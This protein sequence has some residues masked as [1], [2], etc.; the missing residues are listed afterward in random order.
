MHNQLCTYQTAL[1]VNVW[2]PWKEK[3]FCWI[4]AIILCTQI[5]SRPT[6]HA[7]HDSRASVNLFFMSLFLTEASEKVWSEKL[8]SEKLSDLK[9]TQHPSQHTHEKSTSQITTAPWLILLSQK[10]DTSDIRNSRAK[11]I[12][13]PATAG[14]T[15]G[16]WK[17]RN[18]QSESRTKNKSCVSKAATKASRS[19]AQQATSVILGLLTW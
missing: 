10:P 5:K 9:P 13:L 11:L 18:S 14:K 2:F 19:A 8:W 7:D 16:S 17:Q 4:N 12:H 15:S 1:T 6:Q 3:G